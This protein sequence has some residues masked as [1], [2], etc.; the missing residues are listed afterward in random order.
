MWHRIPLVL[1]DLIFGSLSVQDRLCVIERVC[2][3]WHK[4]SLAGNYLH[5][6]FCF[7]RLLRVTNT[8]ID[9]KGLDF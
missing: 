4:A 9:R 3:S 5:F 1:L 7:H 8:Y 6:R 2:E